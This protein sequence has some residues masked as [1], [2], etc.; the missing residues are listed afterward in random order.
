MIEVLPC[1]NDTCP[2]CGKIRIGGAVCCPIISEAQSVYAPMPITADV[3][4]RLRDIEDNLRRAA[5][6]LPMSSASQ[7]LG[8]ANY[9]TDL[10]HSIEATTQHPASITDPTCEE[11]RAD[12]AQN[13]DD[14]SVRED[15][16]LSPSRIERPVT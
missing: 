12:N 10:R 4:R 11:L 14:L 15:A 8:D 3:A 16:P 5:H 7:M 2:T 9:L 13:T 1:G 6:H